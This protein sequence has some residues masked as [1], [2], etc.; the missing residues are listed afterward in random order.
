MKFIEV[1]KRG[2]RLFYES[3]GLSTQISP[4]SRRPPYRDNFSLFIE[5]KYNCSRARLRNARSDRAKRNSQNA[6]ASLR[7]T[8]E[9]FPCFVALALG[10]ILPG[11]FRKSST[12]ISD[13]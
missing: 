11:E 1:V 2:W 9:R 3:R 10:R 13:Y 5:R 4:A 7:F 6:K 12:M 8:D